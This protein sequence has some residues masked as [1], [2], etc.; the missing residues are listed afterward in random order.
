MERQK[1][2]G[3]RETRK[4]EGKTNGKAATDGK[5][6]ERGGIAIKGREKKSKAEGGGMLVS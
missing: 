5:M 3:W 4:E 2:G 6:I 1:D